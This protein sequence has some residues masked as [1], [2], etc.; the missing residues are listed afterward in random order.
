MP[1]ISQFKEI[2]S[3]NTERE[4]EMIKFKNLGYTCEN[5]LSFLI[6]DVHQPIKS[7][8]ELQS[9]ISSKNCTFIQKSP[10]RSKSKP[11][12]RHS[13]KHVSFELPPF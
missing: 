1:S 2:M 10:F 3:F 5:P 8:Y 7:K 9:S 11:P 12:R 6:K 4:I 13:K